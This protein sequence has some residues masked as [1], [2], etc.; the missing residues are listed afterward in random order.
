MFGV[1]Y[2]I[3]R[4]DQKATPWRIYP[5]PSLEKSSS[6]V[7]PKEVYVAVMQGSTVAE[8]RLMSFVH[9]PR[10]RVRVRPRHMS[11]DPAK[12]IP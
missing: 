11:C 10:V 3:L 9:L 5:Y 7:D 1:H 2:D 4:C 12:T 6:F 8:D